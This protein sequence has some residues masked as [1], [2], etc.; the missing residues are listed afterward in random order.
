MLLAFLRHFLLYVVRHPHYA[1]PFLFSRQTRIERASGSEMLRGRD[2]STHRGDSLLVLDGTSRINQQNEHHK[3]KKRP[4]HVRFA[5]NPVTSMH[6]AEGSNHRLG[7]GG[8]DYTGRH[9]NMRYSMVPEHSSRHRRYRQRHHSPESSTLMQATHNAETFTTPRTHDRDRHSDQLEVPRDERRFSRTEASSQSSRH[10]DDSA[11][12]NRE[13]VRYAHSTHSTGGSGAVGRYGYAETSHQGSYSHD[14]P[15]THRSDHSRHLEANP[16]ADR[17]NTY[18]M[19]QRQVTRYRS[20]EY[21]HASTSESPGR[22]SLKITRIR[23]IYSPRSPSIGSSGVLTAQ[24]VLRNIEDLSRSFD[25]LSI[26]ARQ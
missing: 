9:G 13:F 11:H 8:P 15:L 10:H 16:N 17:H 18:R 20:R 4:G 7:G 2:Y 26:E 21:K 12:H 5:D 14:R 1:L 6:S 24:R 3:N 25:K 23:V 19:I 22:Y